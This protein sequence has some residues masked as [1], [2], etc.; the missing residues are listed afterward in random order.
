MQLSACAAC[1]VLW[2]RCFASFGTPDGKDIP[3]KHSTTNTAGRHC[4]ILLCIVSYCTQPV[5]W[6]LEHAD[7]S[8]FSATLFWF[9]HILP[10]GGQ[11]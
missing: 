10:P 5:D 8:L 4:S 7:Q 1:Q 6:R 9:V 11:W 2:Y 3:G